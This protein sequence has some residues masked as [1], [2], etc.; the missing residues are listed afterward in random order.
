MNKMVRRFRKNESGEI[1]LESTII[2]VSVLFLLMALLSLCFMFYQQS[3]MTTMANE[4]SSAVAKNYKYYLADPDSNEITITDVN[5]VKKYRLTLG[6]SG[7]QT[8]LNSNLKDPAQKRFDKTS[9]GINSSDVKV[10]CEVYLSGIGRAYVKVTVKNNTEFFLSGLLEAFGF[11]KAEDF[12]AVSIA[13]ITDLSAY[14][15]TV[16]FTNYVCGGMGAVSGIARI[17]DSIKGIMNT[18]K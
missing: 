5:S 1:M 15:S 9:F 7:M 10:T 16:N 3:V 6:T 14:T 13:E 2:L 18:L 8:A 17:Y 11:F 12:E 4:L